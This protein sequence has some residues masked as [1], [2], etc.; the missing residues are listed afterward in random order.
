M[1]GGGCDGEDGCLLGAGA[2]YLNREGT[3]T[4][5]LGAIYGKALENLLPGG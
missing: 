2:K 1:T 3:A 4:G 5:K